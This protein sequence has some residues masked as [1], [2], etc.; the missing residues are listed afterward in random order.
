MLTPEATLAPTLHDALCAAGPLDGVIIACSSDRLAAQTIEAIRLGVPSIFAEKP[1]AMSRAEAADVDAALRATAAPP[2]LLQVG[3]HRRHD[4]CFRELRRNFASTTAQPTDEPTDEGVGV[5]S[6]HLISYDPAP[7]AAQAAAQGAGTSFAETAGSLFV[8]FSTHD[9]DVLRWLTDD[10][11][12]VRTVMHQRNDATGEEEAVI[13]L[14][15]RRTGC[16][17]VV[18]NSR[19]CGYGHDQRAHLLLSN[20]VTSAL[21]TVST[22]ITPRGHGVP[23][24]SSCRVVGHLLMRGCL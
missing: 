12:E 21:M 9:F 4:F 17:A 5:R 19:S 13:V 22:A 1:L 2:P 24:P 3:F 15:G 8:D 20:G 6:V 11:F 10:E 14:H 23:L 18:E 7:P 16:R